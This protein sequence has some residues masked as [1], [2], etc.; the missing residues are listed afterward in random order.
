MMKPPRFNL[1]IPPEDYR[2]LAALD[3]GKLTTIAVIVRRFIALGL[4]LM[5]IQA[6]GGKVIVEDAKGNKKEVVIFW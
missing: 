3:A 1:T 6:S 4:W 5:D 2:K